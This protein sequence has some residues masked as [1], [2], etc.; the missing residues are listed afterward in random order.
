[1]TTTADA[2]GRDALAARIRH[3]FW[4]YV[5][6]V[7]GLGL[8]PPD[9]EARHY[10]LYDGGLDQADRKHKSIWLEL[11]QW[12]L[13][14]KIDVEAL[15]RDLTELHME[16]KCLTPFELRNYPLST[17]P[18]ALAEHRQRI[19]KK[20]YYELD[21]ERGVARVALYSIAQV[22]KWTDA[23]IRRH[24]ILDRMLGLSPLF[25]LCLA[26]QCGEDRLVAQFW[27]A[28]TEQYLRH[29]DSYDAVYGPHLPDAF[30]AAA[31]ACLD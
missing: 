4:R 17:L 16:S 22:R 29:P 24:V 8:Y 23:E 1:M 9:V 19:M 7:G 26:Q 14:A 18:V 11:A 13:E 12:G 2:G 25:R 3:R 21:S 6:A 28:A 27:D 20:V 10:P 31:R 30:R 5:R 15:L